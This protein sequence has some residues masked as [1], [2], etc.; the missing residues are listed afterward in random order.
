MNLWPTEPV[1]PS[2]PMTCWKFIFEFGGVKL[3]RDLLGGLNG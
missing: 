2:T 3:P 1:Q